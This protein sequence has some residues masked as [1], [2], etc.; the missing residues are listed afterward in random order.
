MSEMERLVRRSV[1]FLEVGFVYCVERRM[2][3]IRRV[4][5][6]KGVGIKDVESMGLL[7]MVLENSFEREEIGS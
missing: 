4:R 2:G 7:G 5:F 6:L 1:W 3:E